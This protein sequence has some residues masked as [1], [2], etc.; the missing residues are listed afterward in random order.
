VSVRRGE[1]VHAVDGDIGRVQGLIITPRDHQVTHI[2]LQEGHF[3]GRKQVAIPIRAV[4]GVADGIRLTIT[5]EQVQ[6]LP[7]VDVQ[8]FE[9]R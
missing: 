4:S 6:Q 1:H 2:L 5:K 7:P 8:S 9:S 3:W